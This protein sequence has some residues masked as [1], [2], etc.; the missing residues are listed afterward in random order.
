M[1]F[2]KTIKWTIAILLILLSILLVLFAVRIFSKSKPTESGIETEAEKTAI[3]VSATVVSNQSLAEFIT[4]NG[5]TKFLKTATIRSNITGYVTA[6]HYGLNSYV[7]QGSLF[8]N[9]K[10]KEQDALKEIQKIDT[11]LKVFNKPLTVISNASG[12]ITTLNIHNGD[13]VSEGDVLA[14]VTEPSSLIIAVNVPYEFNKQ[15]KA[16]TPCEI[17]FSDN[18]KMNLNISGIL[19]TVDAVAQTQTYF[20]QMPTKN[21]PEN[22]NVTIKL[23][24]HNS[25]SNSLTI[26]TEALQADELQKEFWVMKIQKGIAFKTPV[27]I[28]FQTASSVEIKSGNIAI[29]DSIITEGGYQLEDSSAIFIRK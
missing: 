8:C 25:S 24:T 10:T 20:I 1:T 27:V 14:I 18:T 28:G 6:L 3:E 12:L 26:P 11:S 13:Y 17:I 22:L 23:M 21:L 5:V 19:P 2:N 29:G 9:V 16:G 4:L 7:K 15:V